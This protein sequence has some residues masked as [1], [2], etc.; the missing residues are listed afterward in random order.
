M[1]LRGIV[2]AIEAQSPDDLT[3]VVR[4]NARIMSLDKAN[5]K[6]LVEIKKLHVPDE[7]LVGG[8]GAGAAAVASTADD[9]DLV[10]GGD[11]FSPTA[12]AASGE[13]GET[14]G[15]AAPDVGNPDGFDLC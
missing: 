8:A 2:Q 5:S 6:L 11:N 10:N 15:Q 3:K 7:D 13:D 12:A 14:A 1:F 4:D 9:L